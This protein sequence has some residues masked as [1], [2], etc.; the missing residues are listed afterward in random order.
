MSC[1]SSSLKK[2]KHIIIIHIRT[3]DATLSTSK[4]VLENLLKMKTLIEETLLEIG[5]IFSTPTMKSDN[6]KAALPVCYHLVDLNMDVLD[7]RNITGKHL[8]R[9]CLNLNKSGSTR[10]AK[11][12]TFKLR[13]LN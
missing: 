10:L 13:N 7:N 8:G 11:N 3:N 4:E 6:G 1:T 12:I 5:V 2:Q 9:K